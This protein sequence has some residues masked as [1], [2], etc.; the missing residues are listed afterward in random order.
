MLNRWTR[1]PGTPV[2][3]VGRAEILED[4]DGLLAKAKAGSGQGLLLAG[5]RGTGKSELL[6]VLAERG[7]RAG[8]RVLKGRARPE[9]LPAPF[10]LVRG[11]LAGEG[12]DSMR[13]SQDAFGG[14]PTPTSIVP[15]ADSA[16][17]STFPEEGVQETSTLLDGF[18][19]LLAPI[20]EQ[21][22][23]GFEI[24]REELL[25]RVSEYLLGLARKRPLLLAID[26]LHLSDSSSVELLWRLGLDLPTAPMLV[27]ATLGTGSAVPELARPGLETLGHSPSYRTSAV[28]S[29]TLPEVTEFVRA[30]LGG[31][32][33][34]P[35][36][37][38]RWYTETEG[39]PL[40]IEHL[41]RSATGFRSRE[42][43]LALLESVNL[44]E[45]IASR[46]QSLG[47]DERRV[48]AHA[49]VLGQE[50]RFS[51]LEAV[52]ELE[53]ER[54]TES[55]DRLVQEGFLREQGQEVYG[56][57]TET[58]R[59]RVYS[60][61]T[62]THRR[63]L[64]RKTGLVLESKGHTGATELGRHFFLGHDHERS[65]KYN[66]TAARNASRDLAF[67]TA[68]ALLA[69]ALESERRRQSPD[70]ATEIRL[71]TEEG[72]LL[73]EGGSPDRSEPLL[74]RALSL[75]RSTRGHESDLAH[76]LLSLAWARYER[77]EYPSAEELA[78]EAWK[79]LPQ[80]GTTHDVL[81]LHRVSGLSCWRRGNVELASTHLRAALEIAEK[82]GT[83]LERGNALVDVAN[84]VVA[85]SRETLQPVLDLYAQAASLFVQEGN[86]V[87]LARVL[88]NRS[89]SEW[90]AGES[91][92]A[93]EDLRSAIQ[94]AERAHSARW[95]VWCQFNLAQM[96]VELGE[97]AAARTSLERASRA[98]TPG[99]DLFAEQQVLMTRGMIERSEQAYEAA[100]ASFQASLDLA[101][102]LNVPADV[103]EVLFRQA[104]LALDRGEA[105]RAQQLLESSRASDLLGYHPNFADRV[106]ALEKTL[107]SS[108]AS[109][110]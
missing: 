57:V 84:V 44:P 18:D 96:Q 29:F 5:E 92:P 36:D 19:R 73:T 69:R 95:I 76:A 107:D 49:A 40:F 79:Y 8:F 77:G 15:L 35:R 72:R 47:R 42:K 3:L 28:R 11:L 54:V 58:V 109:T 90:E 93:L 102:R 2:T 86:R 60:D 27:V 67:E 70:V 83:P 91:A 23:G 16:L 17:P 24:T 100:E 65:V 64:H 51:D 32:D 85:K 97:T 78:N 43:D 88:M 25:G 10:S 52:T 37:V 98:L 22:V 14:P 71:L 99:V 4:V 80:V 21:G 74:V 94:E 6:G 62:E 101:R 9:E 48:L 81:S 82:E 31:R 1:N 20:V 63:I 68:A 33:P 108:H 110:P 50:F 38:L 56:F 30:I 66:I 26:D 55:V 34:D 105:T 87:A 46:V 39:N 89:W 12:R 106:A 45:A 7:A 41:V 104:E 53:E 75:A 13:T 103:A 61:L 59:V